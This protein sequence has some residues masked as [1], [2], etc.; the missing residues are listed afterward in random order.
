MKNEPAESAAAIQVRSTIKIYEIYYF[1]QD[2]CVRSQR[3]VD[4]PLYLF[5]NRFLIYWSRAW[6]G[7]E[8]MNDS[9]RFNRRANWCEIES[10]CEF[11]MERCGE[12]RVYDSLIFVSSL[13]QS[14]VFFSFFFSVHSKNNFNFGM[15]I[16]WAASGDWRSCVTYVVCDVL[17]FRISFKYMRHRPIHPCAV[18]MWNGNAIN[19]IEL[20]HAVLYLFRISAATEATHTCTLTHSVSEILT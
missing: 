20:R 13:I 3:S 18:H 9:F 17:Q 16:L 4:E 7:E 19:Q 8:W 11:A 2:E 14:Q 10:D 12:G 15:A 5:E 1:A 6:P